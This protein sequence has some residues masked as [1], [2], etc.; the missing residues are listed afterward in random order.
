[1]GIAVEQ[2]SYKS[3]EFGNIIQKVDRF[4]PSSKRCHVCLHVN[5]ELDLSERIWR[6][7]N[8]QTTHDRDYNAAKNLE[9]E[10]ISLLVGSG[11]VDQ[12]P[13]EFLTT[14]QSSEVEQ[15]G[16]YEAGTFVY[17]CVQKR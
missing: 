5:K 6:C 15:A 10:G 12:T 14:T 11:Y 9:M 8:C 16:D 4:F 3:E 1:I 17:I 7:P 2:L 13:V